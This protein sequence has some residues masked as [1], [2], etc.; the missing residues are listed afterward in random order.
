MKH[1]PMICIKW[2][3]SNL[4]L[5]KPPIQEILNKFCLKP[6]KSIS[7][8]KKCLLLIAKSPQ[9]DKYKESDKKIS[10]DVYNNK[11]HT[12]EDFHWEDEVISKN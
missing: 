10:P 6:K 5:N 4:V 2:G 11:T 8:T 9:K 1:L 3:R 12:N 7:S